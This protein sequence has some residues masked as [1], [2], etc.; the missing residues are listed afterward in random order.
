[1]KVLV[2]IP[3]YNEAS[4]IEKVI[5]DLKKHA[6]FADY[7]IIDDCS[8]DNTKKI[9]QQNH[10]SY[11]SFTSNLG[12][13]GGVQAGYKYAFEYEYD[14]AIQH[15]GD[16]QHDPKYINDVIQPIVDNSCDIV[17]GSRF[18]TKEG[19]QSSSTRR[20][21]IRFL[22][23][24]IWLCTGT[25]VKDVTSGFR[26]VNKEYIKLYASEYPQDYPEPE[27]I[28][29]GSLNGARIKEIPVI[30]RERENGVSSISFRKSIY[31]M[32]KVSISIIICRISNRR[33][34]K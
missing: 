28:V 20:M 1:M 9:C 5:K 24:L 33:K 27:A 7:L 21:G 32:L 14:I 25:K 22:S 26:A 4:N 11:L 16:G 12:I 34:R 15:D 19:F 31:Y 3:A 8:K 17:I 10:L 6:P 30:M 18:I 13:G 2:I 23:W 29:V